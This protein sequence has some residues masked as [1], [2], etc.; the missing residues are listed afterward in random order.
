MALSLLIFIAAID[1]PLLMRE[2]YMNDSITKTVPIPIPKS[3]LFR[4]EI[5]IAL[6]VKLI[7]IVGL[8]FLIFRWS[9]KPIE[10]PDI[11]AHFRLENSQSQLH[12]DFNSQITQESHHV[13]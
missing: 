12:A 7:L 11:A 9:D 2:T 3:N 4:W 10:K 5:S 1:Q 8:W 13:R 6:L